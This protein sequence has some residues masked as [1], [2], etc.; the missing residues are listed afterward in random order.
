MRAKKLREEFVKTGKRLPLFTMEDLE[1]LFMNYNRN[2]EFSIDEWEDLVSEV[3]GEV[4]IARAKKAATTSAKVR[5]AKAK[6]KRAT[7]KRK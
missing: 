6:A 2:S 1:D 7:T 3:L 5:R 4:R